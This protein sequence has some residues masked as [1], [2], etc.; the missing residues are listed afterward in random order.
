MYTYRQT[1]L[2]WLLL[3]D[4]CR[5]WCRLMTHSWY[6]CFWMPVTCFSSLAHLFS[7]T[8][9]KKT[10]SNTEEQQHILPGQAKGKCES[11][12]KSN[13][14]TN[15]IRWDVCGENNFVLG[16]R[17]SCFEHC[18]RA[19]RLLFYLLCIKVLR[20]NC[21]YILVTQGIPQLMHHFVHFS[22]LPARQENIN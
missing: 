16:S 19:P 10:K 11:V 2:I 21:V 6:S 17:W 20:G 7:N 3:V 8:C 1:H 5:S 4:F 12:K 15:S 9:T 13:K 14:I 22:C 18:H